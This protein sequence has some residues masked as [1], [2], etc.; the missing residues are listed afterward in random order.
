MRLARENRVINAHCTLYQVSWLSIL[1]LHTIICLLLCKPLN[2]LLP[3][4]N[5]KSYSSNNSL[6]DKDTKLIAARQR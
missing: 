2:S 1:L 4:Q 6:N 3:Q 5:S